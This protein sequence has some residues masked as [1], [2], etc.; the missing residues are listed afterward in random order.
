MLLSLQCINSDFSSIMD[1]SGKAPDVEVNRHLLLNTYSKDLLPDVVNM[2]SQ[3][4]GPLQSMLWDAMLQCDP[5]KDLSRFSSSHYLVCLECT[6]PHGSI[7]ST[8]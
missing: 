7:Q 6:A 3:S 8:T 2:V 1:T 4:F 5:G